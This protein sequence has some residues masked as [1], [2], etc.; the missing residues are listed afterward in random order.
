MDSDP[1]P[2]KAAVFVG[3]AFGFMLAMFFESASPSTSPVILHPLLPL[4][5]AQLA[6]VFR[7]LLGAA[8]GAVIGFV[9]FKV[10]SRKTG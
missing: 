9:V 5:Q 6:E 8:V 10:R 4:T 2:A 3:A 1:M 7:G